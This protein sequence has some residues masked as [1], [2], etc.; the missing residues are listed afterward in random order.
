M[1]APGHHNS[2][3]NHLLDALP[4]GDY[5]RLK[6]QLELIPMPLGELLYEPG[7]R[8]RHVY[9]HHVHRFPAV[10]HGGWRVG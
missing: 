6:S 3:Q 7:A 9:F 10:R 2:Q 8:L 4:D 5:A 1:A